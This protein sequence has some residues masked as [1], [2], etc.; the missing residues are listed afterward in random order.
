MQTSNIIWANFHT[1]I[2][3][4]ILQYLLRIVHVK[5]FS[6]CSSGPK[7]L[8]KWIITRHNVN[9]VSLRAIL[10]FYMRWF[11]QWKLMAT[12][13]FP[14][15]SFF[16]RSNI[17]LEVKISCFQ[18]MTLSTFR[19]TI[20]LLVWHNSRMHSFII[21]LLNSIICLYDKYSAMKVKLWSRVTPLDRLTS[22]SQLIYQS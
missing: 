4:P 22:S 16:L 8:K 15:Y 3:Q 9:L 17:I 2:V 13:L 12:T 21:L 20:M 6:Q 10:F 14:Q 5:M 11:M 7:L 19:K 1:F 18:K